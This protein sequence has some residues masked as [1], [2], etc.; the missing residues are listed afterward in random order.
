MTYLDFSRKT[1][2]LWNK[3][4]RSKNKQSR[5]K[6]GAFEPILFF[7]L[8]THT[9]KTEFGHGQASF[10]SKWRFS[11]LSSSSFFRHIPLIRFLSFSQADR[12]ALLIG[13]N[14]S[15]LTVSVN[16]KSFTS[17]K[18]IRDNLIRIR[19]ILFFDIVFVFF[20][21]LTNLTK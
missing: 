21:I 9:K 19:T 12:R 1:H 15:D 2:F 6:S 11:S 20:S 18:K 14:I 16:L 13:R 17:E 4:Y 7:I 5:R 8:I 10:A 3:T